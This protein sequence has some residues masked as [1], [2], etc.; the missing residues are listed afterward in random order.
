MTATAG[1]EL[2]CR[3]CGVFSTAST[4]MLI[5]TSD[6]NP[7]EE[8]WVWGNVSI[9]ALIDFMARGWLELT[10]E[11]QVF[12]L[13]SR[14]CVP[15]MCW[16]GSFAGIQVNMGVAFGLNAQVAA[17]FRAQL[18]LT[19]I[20]GYTLSGSVQSHGVRRSDGEF[21]MTVIKVGFDEPQ[22]MSSP[23]PPA[24]AVEVEASA[25]AWIIPEIFIGLFGGVDSGLI[26][27]SAEASVMITKKLGARVGF[28][29]QAAV[30]TTDGWSVGLDAL[31][32]SDQT[33]CALLGGL[34][35]QLDGFDFDNVTFSCGSD[36]CSYPP[37][38]NGFCRTSHDTQLDISLLG[39]L[40]VMMKLNASV[41][42]GSWRSDP[43][44][45]TRYLNT[46]GRLQIERVPLLNWHLHV[47]SVCGNLTETVSSPPISPP[48][49]ALPS[50]SPPPPRP[51]PPPPVLPP[52][53][54]VPCPS[55]CIYYGSNCDSWAGYGY[56][57]SMLSSQ[58][59]CDCSGCACPTVPPAPPALPP[60]SSPPPDVCPS[61]C[62]IAATMGSSFEPSPPTPPALN[63]CDYWVANGYSCSA[64]SSQYGCDCS[65]CICNALPPS[66]YPPE[67]SPP[68][69]PPPSP[70]IQCPSTCYSQTCD[71]WA[72]SGYTCS[73]L[74]DQYGCDC[75]G[76][77]C[78][79]SPSPPP[80]WP[81]GT[82]VLCAESC[83]YASDGICDDGGPGSQYVDCSQGTDCIDCGPRQAPV[84]LAGPGTFFNA[85]S[86][87]C[88]IDC[89][90]GG[91]RLEAAE[92]ELVCISM[93][94]RTLHAGAGAEPLT[95]SEVVSGFLAQHPELV[96]RPLGDIDHATLAK[97]FEELSA[98]LFG[99]PA[100]A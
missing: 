80:S 87:Q 90:G 48:P 95:S 25:T 75:S 54:P 63:T 34:Q 64:L 70:P 30:S 86:N 77:S 92:D 8:A 85:T 17:D 23:Q 18:T 38:C 1:V 55:T 53:S 32:S 33:E 49:P 56:S 52:S 62:S 9:T 13:V 83:N 16:G 43:F 37:Y 97:H 26:T 20:E 42:F 58:F 12:P 28:Q 51:S 82:P 84:P 47:T 44:D 99:Q 50:P 60:P 24:L 5:R 73:V 65:G 93:P 11:S 46:S 91:R 67:P 4:H 100:L 29:F 59:S 22:R 27:V 79:P 88:E 98:Q 45:F 68:P 96:S 76:C 74:A 81:A 21:D 72:A 71:D 66:P 36:G 3:D 69:P 31:P 35:N 6:T 39:E 7:F 19:Y 89:D 61:T 10:Y 15:P 2:R 41:G 57:C 14:L 40:T 78:P 94:A